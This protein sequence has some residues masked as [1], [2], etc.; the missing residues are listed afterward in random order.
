MDNVN[1]NASNNVITNKI[2]LLHLNTLSSNSAKRKKSKI[3]FCD[4]R[5]S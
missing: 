2:L 4:F 1:N 3:P 5:K